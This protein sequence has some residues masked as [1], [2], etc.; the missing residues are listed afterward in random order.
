MQARGRGSDRRCDRS[1]DRR[2]QNSAAFLPYITNPYLHISL[3]ITRVVAR[4]SYEECPESM[5]KCLFLGELETIYSIS[6]AIILQVD[7][8]VV[9][10]GVGGIL[11]T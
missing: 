1:Q 10:E 3:Q 5:S 8:T 7:N 11:Q 9:F 4:F 6:L 2:P